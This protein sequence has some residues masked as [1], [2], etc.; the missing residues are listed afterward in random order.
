MDTTDFQ[1]SL[2][3]DHWNRQ[4]FNRWTWPKRKKTCKTSDVPYFIR[5]IK[6]K[7]TYIPKFTENTCLM[8]FVCFFIF[9]FFWGNNTQ[10]A[11]PKNPFP[12]FFCCGR[13][14][15][16]VQP[17]KTQKRFQQPAPYNYL[18]L[19]Q[20]PAWYTAHSADCFAWYFTGHLEYLGRTTMGFWEKK[21]STPKDQLKRPSNW[22]RVKV[23]LYETQRVFGGPQN[24]AS[25]VKGSWFL[26][27]DEKN[28]EYISTN[29]SMCF[30][31]AQ[32]TLSGEVVFKGYDILYPVIN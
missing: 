27:S 7:T 30:S 3:L 17:P 25:L 20:Q 2:T 13:K 23:N 11:P 6:S 24:D 32:L 18:S 15:T 14:S 19:P 12:Q 10:F 21:W 22:V 29:D 16:K 5:N 31:E 9:S 4:V 28:H 1:K 8:M 26:R